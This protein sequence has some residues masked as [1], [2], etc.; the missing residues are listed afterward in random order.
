MLPPYILVCLGCDKNVPRRGASSFSVF[1][2]E[3]AGSKGAESQLLSYSFQPF[4]TAQRQLPRSSPATQRALQ[5]GYSTLSY[6]IY[7]YYY[8]MTSS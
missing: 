3:W 6:N 8:K 5:A 1:S 2:P 7:S 4:T